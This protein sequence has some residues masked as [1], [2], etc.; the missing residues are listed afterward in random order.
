MVRGYSYRL[1]EVP[2][3][4]ATDEA[5]TDIRLR[6]LF[7]SWRNEARPFLETA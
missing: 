2:R 4:L 7:A 6:P 1:P 3:Y 5:V